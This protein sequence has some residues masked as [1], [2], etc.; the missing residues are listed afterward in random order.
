MSDGTYSYSN[1]H[2]MGVNGLKEGDDILYSCGDMVGSGTVFQIK[3]TEII[4]QTGNGA[5][6]LEYINKSQVIFK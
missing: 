2:R 5:R 4:V 6:G 1:R 3:E